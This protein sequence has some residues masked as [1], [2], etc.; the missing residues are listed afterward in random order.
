MPRK[1][2]SETNYSTSVRSFWNVVLGLTPFHEHSVHSKDP[3][4][5]PSPY[6][7]NRRVWIVVLVALSIAAFGLMME[8]TRD[9]PEVNDDSILY[10]AA[11]KNILDGNGF[12]WLSGGGE[13]SPITGFPPAYSVVIA[14]AGL[15]GMDLFEGA[16]WVNA[17]LFGTSALLVGL[18]ILQ[19]T[20]SGS[21]SVI[22]ALLVVCNSDLLFVH[23]W[24]MAEVLFVPLLLLT[25]LLLSAY[26]STPQRSLALLSG[27]AVALA[28]LTR[29]AGVGLLAGSVLGVGLLSDT[30]RWRKFQ[31]SILVA[32]VAVVPFAILTLVNYSST[33]SAYHR[34]TIIEAPTYASF[35]AYL[36]AAFSL[37]VP[38][39][40]DASVRLRWKVLTLLL[41]LVVMPLL[42]YVKGRRTRSGEPRGSVPKWGTIPLL[43]SF[44]SLG[45]M[46]I[47]VTATS[48]EDVKGYHLQRYMAPV[49]VS[50]VV[51]TA[52]VVYQV[53]WN[54]RGEVA[55]KIGAVALAVLFL[56][57]SRNVGFQFLQDRG[58]GPLHDDYARAN[59]ETLK[60]LQQLDPSEFL[61]T[62]EIY[63][64]YYL[65]YRSSYQ[66][67]MLKDLSTDGFRER[68]GSP[69]SVFRRRMAEGAYLILFDSIHNQQ[70]MFPS[71]ERLTEGLVSQER[72][73]GG[74][75]YVDPGAHPIVP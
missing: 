73:A 65:T 10:V 61:Y 67:P 37:F 34:E 18:L 49:Y 21:A 25:I 5:L 55:L 41:I 69:L 58:A 48:G 26:L 32:L 72:I 74:E 29:Y 12:S 42:L 71:P 62:N 56:V 9:G 20:R 53:A 30:G 8:S 2:V 51:L 50:W 6:L 27:L 13:V 47:L 38:V 46:V 54:R 24:I 7:R 63:L 17:V 44:L 39:L 68:S 19:A 64:V 60:K 16:R 33:G 59:P 75:V 15:T 40:P 3:A 23:R 66:V 57:W 31:D 28:I 1:W 4:V 14:A 43:A 11:A 35:V 36:N 52:S 22:G 70:A 45:Y